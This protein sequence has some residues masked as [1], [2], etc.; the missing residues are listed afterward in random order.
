MKYENI[1]QDKIKELPYELSI[2]CV[3]Y[4]KWKNICNDENNLLNEEQIIYLLQNDIIEINNTFKQMILNKKNNIFFACCFKIKNYDDDI[5]YNFATL[6]TQCLYKIILKLDKK[7]NTKIRSWY[8]SE[9][10]KYSFY[11]SYQLKRIEINL[12]G[13]ND[14]CPIC[15]E[16]PK[17]IFILNC[18]HC[19]CLN[20]FEYIYKIKY[21]NNYAL[22]KKIYKYCPQCPLC[23]RVGPFKVASKSQILCLN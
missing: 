17:E 1:W 12:Y 3:N 2:H 6:N 22:Y 4:K 23:R 8:N 19:I 20:C 21:N 7:L 15:L 18:G 16:N 11:N 13:F 5:I 14:E 9:I 10:I